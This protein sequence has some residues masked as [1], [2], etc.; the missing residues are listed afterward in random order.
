MVGGQGQPEGRRRDGQGGGRGNRNP[1]APSAR[2]RRQRFRV[3]RLSVGF[4]CRGRH[5]RRDG[6]RRRGQRGLGGGESPLGRDRLCPGPGCWRRRGRWRRRIAGTGG[7]LPANGRRRER[8]LC[9]RIGQGDRG[10]DDLQPVQVVD[11]RRPH[12]HAGLSRHLEVRRLDPWEGY[13][14]GSRADR[15]IQRSR[16][17]QDNHIAR[18][19]CDTR[20]AFRPGRQGRR[21][22]YGIRSLPGVPQTARRAVVGLG[23]RRRG[24]SRSRGVWRA[25]RSTERFVVAR[26]RDGR[27]ARMGIQTRPAAERHDLQGLEV[28]LWRRPHEGLIGAPRSRARGRCRKGPR[29]LDNRRRTRSGVGSVVCAHAAS[30]VCFAGSNLAPVYRD[31]GRRGA[32]RGALHGPP[33]RAVTGPRARDLSRHVRERRRRVR[34]ALRD[35]RA[36]RRAGCPTGLFLAAARPREDERG[37]SPTRCRRFTR[38]TY[39]RGPALTTSGAQPAWNFLK[40][41]TKRE[42]SCRYFCR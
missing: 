2:R 36:G 6:L 7:D 32:R 40:F 42:A 5:C 4:G 3:R 35:A 10:V 27:K 20:R 11:R 8:C 16:R 28:G 33:A 19:R 38:G 41:S 13:G 26:R 39:T 1:D 34:R 12:Q 37:R 9:G 22:R 14:L 25:C 30:R 31:A 18:R 21:D 24:G 15:S 17:W 23:S 29:A